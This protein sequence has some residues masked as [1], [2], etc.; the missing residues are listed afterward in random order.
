MVSGRPVIVVAGRNNFR[1]YSASLNALIDDLQAAGYTV[2][3][4]E[5]RNTTTSRWLDSRSARFRKRQGGLTKVIK[6]LILL[7]RPARWDYFL[8]F[9][10]APHASA[11]RDLRRLIRRLP[12]SQVCL[13]SHSAGGIVATRVASEKTVTKLVCFGYPFKHPDRVDEPDR[14]AHL[15]SLNKPFLIIQGDQDDYG[16]AADA[17]RYGLSASTVVASVVA[18]HGYDNL[19]PAEYRRCLAMVLDFLDG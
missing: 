16:N 6:L 5:P 12:D 3:R 4:L 1:E 19:D 10:E 2:C 17:Q 11:A 9:A 15:G 18:G 7:T 8:K 14:T 13:V